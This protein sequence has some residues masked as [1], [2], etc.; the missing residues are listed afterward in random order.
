MSKIGSQVIMKIATKLLDGERSSSLSSDANAIDVSSKLSGNV[1]NVEYG[2]TNATFTV[3]SICDITPGGAT[4]FTITDALNAQR[5]KTKVAVLLT[6][7]TDKTAATKVE[8]DQ[9]FTGTC[10]ITNVS[11]EFGDDAENTMTLTLQVDG[12]LTS[13]VNPDLP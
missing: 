3:S 11:G 9:S 8:L 5:A 6:G 12:E 13:G 7:Y 2:R 10:I 4:K 1:T